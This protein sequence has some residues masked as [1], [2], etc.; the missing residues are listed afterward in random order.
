MK[1]RE[2]TVGA[3]GAALVLAAAG[4][5]FALGHRGS[6][7]VVDLSLLVL[8]T[9]VLGRLEFEVSNGFT[10]PTQLAFVPMLFVLPPAIVPLA[11]I[12]ATVL[13]RLPDLLHGRWHPQ[14]LL[15]SVGDAWFAVGPALVFV[16]AGIT[17]PSLADWPI[18]AIALTA[19]LAGNVIA[20]TISEW[21]ALGVA[22]RP[23]LKVVG[24][25]WLVDVM[26]SPIGL[27]AAY[28]TMIEPQAYLLVLPLAGVI[29]AFARERRERIGQ[30]IEL[31]AAYRG[32]ANLLGEVLTADDEY[33]G[34][35]SQDVVV[36][37][38]AIA[39]ELRVDADERRLVEFGAMLHDI[40]KIN[41]PPE[42]LNKPG[43][44]TDAEWKI[45]RQHTIVGQA[46]LDRVGGTLHEVGRVVR[47][48]HERFDGG[49]YPD[50]LASFEIPLAARIVA[51]ADA[52]DAMTTH[53]P[54]RAPL[55]QDFALS[56][57]RDGEG[58]QFDPFVVYAAVAALPRLSPVG[59]GSTDPH[60]ADRPPFTNA[61][62]PHAVPASR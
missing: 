17:E 25:V 18:F 43:P 49:G 34:V 62:S 13:D 29:P 5:L 51:V 45:M 2:L 12:A 22:L 50:G 7:D 57:L 19:Q 24:R 8:A 14:R 42:I 61:L 40:G 47:A 60:H 31:S 21:M 27:V 44:L 58:S 54:Y 38:L 56:E 23:A 10:V 6:I 36:F 32:T 39:D 9:A 26:L 16:L 41:T 11:V 52:Y 1:P 46:M 53:R 33:T 37:A 48:S 55:S 20:A 35:H 3:I 28:A 30:A 59:A 4:A 15:L